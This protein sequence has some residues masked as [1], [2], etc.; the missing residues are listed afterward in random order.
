MAPRTEGSKPMSEG[1]VLT[2]ELPRLKKVKLE[3]SYLVGG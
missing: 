3:T 1:F 2:G